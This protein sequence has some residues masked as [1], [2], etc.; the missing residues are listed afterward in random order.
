MI[1]SQLNVNKMSTHSELTLDKFIND[2]DI[3][4]IALQETGSWIPSTGIFQGR[5]V[6]QNTTVSTDKIAE[7][8]LIIKEALKPEP[9]DVLRND[10]LDAVFMCNIIYDMYKY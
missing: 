5:K 8:A 1:F 4:A 9:I 7:V 3:S 2:L 10:E 6:Y